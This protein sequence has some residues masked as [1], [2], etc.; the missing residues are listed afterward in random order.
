MGIEK[1][2]DLDKTMNKASNM[3]FLRKEG[4]E[5]AVY[6]EFY[7]ALCDTKPHGTLI[8]EQGHGLS[9]EEMISIS[10]NLRNAGYGWEKWFYLPIS[11]FYRFSSLEYVL[12][13]KEALLRDKG[14]EP[15]RTRCWV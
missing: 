3:L 13:H 12:K 15:F 2:P 14:P 1:S 10:R 4:D 9:L 8:K 6:R 5:E 11:A 7:N